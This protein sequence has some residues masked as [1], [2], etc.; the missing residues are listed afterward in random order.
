MANFSLYLPKLQQVEGGYQNNNSDQGNKNSLGQYVGT[1]FGISARFYEQIIGRPPSVEDMK[2]ITKV[3]ARNLYQVHFWNANLGDQI[4]SQSVAETVIDHHI[5]S[6]NGIILAQKL[7]NKEYAKSLSED[8]AMGP[9]TL[10]A[11]NSVNAKSFTE[12]YNRDR[13]KYYKT[14]H[15]SDVFASGWLKRLVSFGY[16]HQT[17]ISLGLVLTITG[18]AVCSWYLLSN[19]TNLS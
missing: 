5:N 6:G 15:N 9:Q 12:D 13:A 8:N 2:A 3:K 7:L 17:A 18:V 11:L 1:Q 16:Q 4:K 19:H 10:A 14:R